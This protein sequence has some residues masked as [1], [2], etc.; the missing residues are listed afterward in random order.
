MCQLDQAEIDK[1]EIMFEGDKSRDASPSIRGF[2]F[3][4]Y[5][6]INSLL[7]NG[8]ECV[9]SEYLEDVDVFFENGN[10]EF[11]QAKHYPGTDP[12]QHVEEIFTDLYYQY[13]RLQL[14]HS[15]LTAYPKLYIHTNPDFE[16]LLPEEVKKVMPFKSTLRKTATY[17]NPTD[18]ET[19]LRK[20]VYTKEVINKQGKK[21]IKKQTKA[22]QKN[23]L[24]TA[25][26]S[27]ASL[28]GF[29]KAIEVKNL[30]EIR[31]YRDNVMN[32]LAASYPNP[33]PGNLDDNWQMI[34]LGIALNRIHQR[35]LDGN[36]DFLKLRVLKKEFDQHMR[37]S[38]QTKSDQ[39]IASYLTAVVA[40]RYAQIMN[41]NNN[42]II[43]IYIL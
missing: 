10:F 14:L 34:L 35:Y 18:T 9:C 2:L 6:V 4:D 33:T 20:N 7:Q 11:I 24:F 22:E 32:A 23:S 43:A 15:G 17:P 42:T 29:S 8:V 36:T 39:T 28:D 26:A 19:W 37:N 27:E 41:D 12:K 25:M 30:P 13:L 1:L 3:Q 16:K 31:I 5:I 40:E 38:V 21:E